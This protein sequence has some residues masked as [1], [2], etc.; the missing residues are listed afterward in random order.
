MLYSLFPIYHSLSEYQRWIFWFCFKLLIM[1]LRFG[2][3]VALLGSWM[4]LSNSRKLIIP[5]LICRIVHLHAS[6]FLWFLFPN[7][8]FQLLI[9]GLWKKKGRKGEYSTSLIVWLLALL[10]V[11]LF[12]YMFQS[13]FWKLTRETPKCTVL[14]LH[15]S[16]DFFF[17]PTEGEEVFAIWSGT[18][19]CKASWQESLIEFCVDR[20]FQ[21]KSFLVWMTLLPLFLHSHLHG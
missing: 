10:C 11:A 16:Y 1:D 15:A 6:C 18:E 5:T 2:L 13:Y 7:M 12:R 21:L 3:G 14:R 9:M 8:C 17:L 20:I 19:G 4:F